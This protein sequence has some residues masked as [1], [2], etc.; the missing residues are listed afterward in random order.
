[1]LHIENLA[2]FLPA[3]ILAGRSRARVLAAGVVALAALWLLLGAPTPSGSTHG[4]R[5]P[6]HLYTP[7]VALWG[8]TRSLVY[9]PYLYEASLAKVVIASSIGALFLLA[10]IASSSRGPS[11]LSRAAVLAWVLPY[12]A[13]GLG[14]FAS[15]SERWIFLLPLAWLF[16]A[17]RARPRHVFLIAAGLVVANCVCWLPTARDSRAVDQARAYASSLRAGDLVLSPGHGWDESIVLYADD[18]VPFPLV[19]HAA[20]RGGLDGLARD[21]DE[22]I[23]AAHA[24]GARVVLARMNDD[25]VLGWKELAVLGIDR[26]AIYTLLRARGL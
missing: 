19:Y 18:I 10:L 3:M 13:V 8:M 5:Y 15:D 25:S 6:L 9:A 11:P 16:V 22:A 7:L 14:F 4:F 1:M 21:L 24:R 26:Q 2:F 17:A 20:L 23:L 12:G